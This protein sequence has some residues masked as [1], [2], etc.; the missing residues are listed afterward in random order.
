M[1]PLHRIHILITQLQLLSMKK[2]LLTLVAVVTALTAW[3]VEPPSKSAAKPKAQHVVLIAIDG[4]GAY[5]VPKAGDRIP[6]ISGLMKRGAYTLHSRSV[7]PSSSAI[8]WASMFNGLPTEQHG[9]TDWNSRTPEIPSAYLG[10]HGMCPTVFTLLRE[11]R[12][13]AVSG[14]LFE[15]DGIKYLIDTL[16]VSHFEQANEDHQTE[17][18]EKA[19]RYITAARPTLVAV[20]FDQLDHA[21]HS[22]GHDTPAY[23]ATLERIDGYV[24]RII[25]ATKRAGIYDNTI[26]VMTADHG[27]VGKGHGGKSL[28]EMEIPFIISGK[29]IKA[30]GAFTEPM[31]QYDTAA[32]LAYALGLDIPQ[33]WRGHAATWAFARSGR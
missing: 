28:L 32:T 5:S 3:A 15:W 7:L 14:C 16:A 29:G 13:E 6:N 22:E 20:C 23:Y 31:M 26:F 19:E 30:L 24:G 27:G 25:E 12:P 33:A 4:W 10:P 17:L 8:N 18:V 21:G 2:I 9:Y 11:Q 1:G